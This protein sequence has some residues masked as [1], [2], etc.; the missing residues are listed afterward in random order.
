MVVSH[1]APVFW[2]QLPFTIIFP[3]N[4][5]L[6]LFLCSLC[7][8]STSHLQF[9]WAYFPMRSKVALQD[10]FHSISDSKNHVHSSNFTLLSTNI[11]LQGAFGSHLFCFQECTE[12]PPR[13]IR[14]RYY[15]E[16]I[17]WSCVTHTHTHF[18]FL[19]VTIFGMWS[20]MQIAVTVHCE[21]SSIVHKSSL[22]IVQSVPFC[23]RFL[24]MFDCWN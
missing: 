22:F 24:V 23:W 2:G 5:I 13:A 6:W 8:N 11:N 4:S 1:W 15:A 9:F 20:G 19:T 18:V 17:L 14:I 16:T 21:I 12:A 3:S 10:R 7:T